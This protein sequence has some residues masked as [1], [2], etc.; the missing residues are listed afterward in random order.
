MVIHTV[1]CVRL[2]FA[3]TGGTVYPDGGVCISILHEPGE[4][5][6]GYED[7]AERWMPVHSTRVW[8]RRKQKGFKLFCVCVCVLF[9]QSS[10]L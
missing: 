6:Y 2:N 4:D 5:K 7:A 10:C 9:R 3:L 8:V 1:R